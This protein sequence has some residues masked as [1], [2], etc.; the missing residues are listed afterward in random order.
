MIRDIKAIEQPLDFSTLSPFATGM[1]DVDGLFQLNN[2]KIVVLE[3]KKD[4]PKHDFSRIKEKIQFNLLRKLVGN[5]SD[6]ILI[7]ATHDQPI[8]INIPIN[9]NECIVRGVEIGGIEQSI[10][11]DMYLGEY[12]RDLSRVTYEQEELFLMVRYP[13]SQMQYCVPMPGKS[14]QWATDTYNTEINRFATR[15]E[16]RRYVNDRFV[17]QDFNRRNQYFLYKI[18]NGLYSIIEQFE[19]KNKIEE[20]VEN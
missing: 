2:G 14:R 5:R 15:D 10:E 8:D 19:Y 7:Y 16:A 9:I 3:V 13:N 17:C 12:I 18:E 6:I 20:F 4:T 1:S 11:K